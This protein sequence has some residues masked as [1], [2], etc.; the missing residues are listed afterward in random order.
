[1]SFFNPLEGS[2]LLCTRGVYIEAPVYEY[3]GELFVK[4][5]RGFLKL[6]S[7]ER[8]SDAKVYWRNI[9]GV[10][11]HENQGHVYLTTHVAKAA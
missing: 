4:R 9:Q 8:T 10:P 3:N 2:A 7:H 11:Y 5:G 1:M 6:L